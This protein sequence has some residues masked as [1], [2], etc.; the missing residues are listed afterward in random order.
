MVFVALRRL[1]NEIYYYKTGKTQEVDFIEISHSREKILFQVCESL[2]NPKTRN[3]EMNALRQAMSELSVSKSVTITLNED[4]VAI[5]PE[6]TITVMPA[7]RFLL[8]MNG[9]RE[10]ASAT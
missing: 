2:I 5:F 9:G 10:S 1:Y 7:W 8:E 3:R 6:G 4:E